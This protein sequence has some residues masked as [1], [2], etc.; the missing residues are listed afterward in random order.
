[1]KTCKFEAFD[2]G[3]ETAQRKDAADIKEKFQTLG[4]EPNHYNR[5]LR[6]E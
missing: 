3:K 1:M 5:Y 2:A 4:N 6:R